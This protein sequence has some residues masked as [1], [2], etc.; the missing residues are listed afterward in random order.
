[1]FLNQFSQLCVH[2]Y[3]IKKEF[4]GQINSWNAILEWSVFYHFSLKEGSW[5][6]NG[7]EVMKQEISSEVGLQT[8]GEVIRSVDCLYLAL[9]WFGVHCGWK[10][11]FTRWILKKHAWGFGHKAFIDG[12]HR[13]SACHHSTLRIYYLRLKKLALL[14]GSKW[15]LLGYLVNT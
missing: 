11:L 7:H 12:L 3:S 4:C 5:W 10:D 8:G 6:D 13:L 15:F 1:M 14:S 2:R 9:S